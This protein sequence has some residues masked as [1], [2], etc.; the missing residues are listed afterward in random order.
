MYHT[1]AR[2]EYRKLGWGSEWELSIPCAQLCKPTTALKNNLIKNKTDI[3][4]TLP[5]C[6]EKKHPGPCHSPAGIINRL[7]NYLKDY[8]RECL[9]VEFLGQV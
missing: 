1:S 7:P 3:S 9:S 4:L 2:C 8:P 6:V 5:F